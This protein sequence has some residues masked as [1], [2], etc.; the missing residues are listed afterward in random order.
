MLSCFWKS[1]QKILTIQT[2]KGG[3]QKLMKLV[4]WKIGITEK[5]K[6]GQTHETPGPTNGDLELKLGIFNDAAGL[7]YWNG[8]SWRSVNSVT[9]EIVGIGTNRHQEQWNVDIFWRR[10]PRLRVDVKR[11]SRCGGSTKKDL[12]IQDKYIYITEYLVYTFQW[13]SPISLKNEKKTSRKR[14]F[15]AINTAVLKTTLFI[16]RSFASD[17]KAVLRPSCLLSALFHSS[18]SL[19]FLYGN[20]SSWCKQCS[21]IWL[22]VTF[23]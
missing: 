20:W 17:K 11:S 9:N 1:C 10:V 16:C 22:R 15:L 12:F 5:R 21:L 13:K 18:L 4:F 8:R 14:P 7:K 23:K 3:K 19:H 2:Q 6:S